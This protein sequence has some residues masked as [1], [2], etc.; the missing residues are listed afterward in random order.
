MRWSRPALTALVLASTL[1]LSG[2]W[3]I[4]DISD[5]SP[6]IAMGFDYLAQDH[7]RVSIVEALLAQGGTASYTGAIHYG[8][9]PTLV[10]AIEDLRTH[11]ARRLYLGSTKIFVF[12][13]GVLGGRLTE[14]LLLLLQSSEVDRTAFAVGTSGTALGLLSHPDGAMGLTGVRLLKEFESEPESRDGH[15]KEPLWKTIWGVLDRSDTMRIPM[16]DNLPQTSVRAS[17]TALVSQGTLRT[18]L[19]REESVSLRWLSNL[20]G[21]NVVTLPAPYDAYV[22]K[23]TKVVPTTRYDGKARRITVHVAADLEVYSGP[24]MKLDSTLMQQLSQV[25]ADEMLRRILSVT[26]KMQAADADGA[27]WH[28]VALEAGYSDFDLRRTTVAVRVTA[29]ITPQFSP[30]L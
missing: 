20:R 13:K 24:A 27:H 25:A 5:R 26:R 12:G 7:W 11:L 8:D 4:K 17:G 30:S 14:P 10:E 9:G 3:D 23:A 19:D 2:C 15:F 16:F 18:L 22:L 29:R 21:R 28:Q 6:V 1:L